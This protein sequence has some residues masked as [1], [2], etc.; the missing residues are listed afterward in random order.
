MNR[1]GL[2]RW[3]AYAMLML[4]A[5]FA[6][7]AS[8]NFPPFSPQFE[9]IG[10][11]QSIPDNVVTSL[12][13]DSVGFLWIGTPAG[14]VRYDGYRF[15]L[16]ASH[17]TDYS[18]ISGNFV[19]AILPGEEGGLWVASEPGGVSYY[20]PTT[21]AFV[22]LHSTD[23]I[24]AEPALGRVTSLALDQDGD[25]LFGTTNGIYRVAFDPTEGVIRSQKLITNGLDNPS[26]RTLLMTPDGR[27]WAGTR[28]GLYVLADNGE[29]FEKAVQG[30]ILE[31][32]SIRTLYADEA[33]R[34]WIG[35]ESVGAYRYSPQS[36]EV[37]AIRSS[38]EAGRSS[39]VNAIG[40]PAD[41]EIWLARHAGILRID[42]DTI[43]LLGEVEH[44]P[45]NRFSLA[46]NDA[47]AML[48][49]RSGIFWVAGYGS[50]VQR[51]TG[52]MNG[53]STLRLSLLQPG[54][55][56][57]ANVSS[58]LELEQGPI[59]IG[60]RG[61]GIDVFERGQG[62]TRGYRPGPDL[63]G[64]W[65]TAMTQRVTDDVWIGV[66][67]GLLYRYQP[68]SGVFTKVTERDGM[69]EAN[70]RFL[71]TDSQQQVWIGTNQ[72][73]GLWSPET[74]AVERLP[75]LDG[76]ELDDGVNSI[77]EGPNGDIWIGTGTSGL[78]RVEQGAY[79]LEHVQGEVDSGADIRSVSILGMLW[80]SQGRFWLDSPD[81]L[82]RGHIGTAL[83]FENVS[84]ALGVGGRPLGANL[85]ED[86]QG[87][88][89][90]SEALFVPDEP[91]VLFLQRAD[92]IDIGTPWYRSFAKTHD[93]ILMFGGSQGL[94]FIDPVR[95]GPWD[96]LPPT[97]VT[98]LR[99]NGVMRAP[100]RLSEGLHLSPQ[101]RSFSVEFSA[102]DYSEPE[103]NQYKYL[104]EGFDTDW[105]HVDASRRVASYSNLWPGE[106][107]L[108]V[109]G[110]N[111]YGAWSEEVLELPIV[112]LA[113]F[114]QTP[115]FAILVTSLLILM[116]YLFVRARTQRL[117]KEAKQ[118]EHLV[119]ER[120]QALQA[121]QRDL[122]ER[123]KM[124]SLGGLVAGVSHEINTPVGIAVT[125]ASTLDEFTQKILRRMN[126]GELTKREFE[127]YGD[128]VSE[129]SRLIL[130]SL[131]RART[132]IASFKQVA[133][134]Q[135]SQQRREFSLCE[136][137]EDISHSLHPIYARGHHQFDL[138]CPEELMVDTYP[139]ALFQVIS[140]LVTNTVTHGF[141]L[142]KPGV[143]RLKVRREG[144]NVR[145]IYRDD[146]QGMSAE[147]LQRAFDPFFTT[148]RGAGGSGLG[149]HL[150]YNFVT[151][152]LGGTI[153]LHSEPG[154]GITCTM[155]IPRVAPEVSES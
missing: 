115:V 86:D 112:I 47:R 59:F 153:E 28:S 103:R 147:V 125:A 142:E 48:Q 23:E 3:L 84:A 61:N 102:L 93:G 13:E 117:A 65:I 54:S 114:W 4:F 37:R 104:L 120:T 43:E 24:F 45:S 129:S 143:I 72:G 71:F 133:V 29:A 80:D 82:L 135:S 122:M 149:L 83:S 16:Y 41:N 57:D 132:L 62:V 52:R 36:G 51:V 44:D 11:S 141:T 79:Q 128:N 9:S 151:Q 6:S 99:T 39:T 75:L 21:D 118:L 33:Q 7:V 55:L 66:N 116:F 123:E 38:I 88:I 14:L 64:G 46:N 152:I 18:T 42:A 10:D 139:G 8:A 148:K 106:Y 60:T 108:L 56:S 90:T 69:F 78:Y 49:D 40:Q 53:L 17:V 20:D 101:E 32:A 77:V 113:A 35:T 137:L 92:G 76:G 27:L 150:V 73:V 126:S 155:V 130:S 119:N 140:N 146:G 50:G 127:Q 1:V 136:L 98:E 124:A 68:S 34:I 109:R 138:D 107:R 131:D 97:V 100:G 15:R 26:V 70:V 22:R 85:M 31:E 89:W 121:A 96:Y 19:R 110:S 87:R 144:Q 30:N 91:R 25:L 105:I 94:L 5:G 58:I 134:D 145:M 67:P 154:Q 2:P 95:F 111:R 63:G 74:A 81:G 12:A